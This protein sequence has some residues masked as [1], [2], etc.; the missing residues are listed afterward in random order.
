MPKLGDITLNVVYGED[1]GVQVK[2]TDKPTEGGYIAA[3]HVEK[4]PITLKISGVCTGD[5]AGTRLNRLEQY[6]KEGKRLTYIGRFQLNNMVITS[7]DSTKDTDVAGTAYKF[8]ISLK[9]IRVVAVA[10]YEYQKPQ[11]E[12]PPSKPAENGGYKPPIQTPAPKRTHTVKKGETLSH[13]AL[14]YYGSARES[15]WM[16]IFEANRPMLKDPHKIYPGQVIVI[17]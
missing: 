7:I 17:P 8:D 16:K 6:S 11:P 12:T 15:F 14:W 9:E 13:Y 4:Q 10:S 5:D 2:T 3:D 1:K